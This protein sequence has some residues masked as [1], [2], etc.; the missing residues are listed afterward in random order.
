[1]NLKNSNLFFKVI[2][3]IAVSVFYIGSINGQHNISMDKAAKVWADSVFN[4]LTLEQQVGQLIFVRANYPDQPYMSQIDTLIRDF[5]IGGVVFFKGDPIKQVVQTNRWNSM[6]KTPLFVSIDAEWGLSMRLSQTVSYPLQMT[7]GSIKDDALIYAMGKQIGAQCKRLGIHINFAPVVDVNSDPSNPVIGMR[8]FGQNPMEVAKKGSMYMLG[9]QKSGIIA[10][11]KHFPGHGNT[12][13]DS[14]KDLPIV[15][16]PIEIL[17]KNDLFPFQYL[18]DKGVSSVMIAHLSVPALD[19][20][21]NL[22]S[23]LSHRIV[24]DYLIDT[25]GFEGLIITDGLDMKGVTKY[26]KEGVVALKAL[27]A[28]NDV[29]LIPD[30]IPLSI[31]NI[32]DAVKSG[33]VSLNRIEHSCKKILKYKY[34]TGANTHTPIETVG[35]ISDLNKPNYGNTSALLTDASITLVKNENNIIPLNP[36]NY[37]KRALLVIGTDDKMEIQDAL[38]NETAFDVYHINH[39]AKKKEA[40]K[41]INKLKS[42]DL[43]V[44][45]MLNT[46]ILASRNFGITDNDVIIINQ[47]SKETSVVL[48][49]FASPY[50]LNFFDLT[51]IE[52]VILSYQE[53]PSAQ[54]SSAKLIMGKATR[55]GSLPVDV[56]GYGMGWGLSYGSTTLFDAKPESMGIDLDKLNKVDSIAQACIE[57]SIFPGC[58]IIAVKDG[59]IFYNKSFG[60]HTYDKERKVRWNDVYDLASLTKILATTPAMMKLVEDGKINLADR[61]SDYLLMLRGTNKDSLLFMEVLAHQSGLQNW[62]PYYESTISD[63]NWNDSIYSSAISETYPIRVAEGM[64]IRSGYDNVLFDSIIQS[65]F[66]DKSYHYSGLGFYLF[67][68]MIE[69]ITNSTFDQ[70]VYDSFYDPLKLKYLVYNPR[71]YYEL[72]K[73]IPTEYDTLF[74]KQLLHGDVHD[75]GAAML[76]G[77]SG[78]AGLFGNTYN[79]AVMMQLF[80]NGGSYGNVKIFDEQTIDFFNTYH[81]VADS[82]RRGLGFD[83]PLHEYEEHRTNCKDASPSSFGHSGFTGTYAWADPETGFI[84]VFLSN[85]VHPDMNNNKLMNL[86]IRTNIHQLFYEAIKPDNK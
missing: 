4:S 31:K 26:Y 47:L 38:N 14:H 16:D 55:F 86:D 18:I 62:I 57:D 78:N 70:Y 29:L 82:N 8:S 3:V 75:Q 40:K 63:G 32:V 60:Y 44:A 76:G 58:Q 15:T 5:N 35:L 36:D 52:S 74:R 9:M 54:I 45:A 49:V 43:V 17:I 13:V 12:H 28:G 2:L 68:Q 37:K 79:V 83:K 1:M 61:L 80:L 48:N 67:K 7:L 34:L 71:R 22:P 64:Y 25:M 19:D 51:N 6:A 20:S 21:P 10:C 69:N 73:I 27:E 66:Q 46:N 72:N 77:V 81:F 30:N 50:A 39:N 11:A 65:P 53:K 33:E 41:L 84:Y 23:T 56:N 59:A 24:S 42:Y 85:R